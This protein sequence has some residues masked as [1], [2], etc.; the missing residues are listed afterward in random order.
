MTKILICGATSFVAKGFADL[1]TQEG[2][3]VDCFSRG[4]Q[5]EREGNIIRGK[6]SE[7]DKNDCLA[8]Q[9]DIVVN[10]AILKDASVQDNIEYLQNLLQMCQEHGVKKLVHF[11]SVMA[12]NYHLPTVDESTQIDT[13]ENTRMKGYGEIKI[14]TDWFLQKKRADMP[15]E[16]ILVRP[17][18]VLADNRPCPFIKHLVGPFYVIKGNKKSKQPIVHR[19]DIHFALLKIIQQEDNLLV[20]HFFPTDGMTKYRFAKENVKGFVLTMPKIIFNGIPYVMMKIG[21][22][23]PS[24]YSRFEGMY[25]ESDFQSLK[26]QEKLNIKFR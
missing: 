16:V 11:S 25:I 8:P 22:M 26:T 5:A 14:A 12:Y 24:L 13:L 15:F 10:F 1:L 7:I 2:F 4:L 23:K 19:E 17:G 6:Y 21:L 3:D 20:Y 9:Y 18:Y